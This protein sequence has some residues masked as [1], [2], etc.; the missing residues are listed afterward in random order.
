MYAGP[1]PS[2]SQ[3]PPGLLNGFHLRYV[4]R[5]IV[6]HPLSGRVLRANKHRLTVGS[7]LR[8]QVH[9]LIISRLNELVDGTSYGVSTVTSIT[10]G[11][12]LHSVCLVSVQTASFF[13]GRLVLATVRLFVWIAGL[14]A[15]CASVGCLWV[16][17][18][19]PPGVQ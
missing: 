12:L 15:A 8:D 6:S 19:F 2:I 18:A 7:Y 5:L 10:P 1:F 16:V 14:E 13:I 4:A 17:P 11:R 9:Q 3:Q